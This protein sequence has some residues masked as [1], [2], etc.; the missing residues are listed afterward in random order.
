[1]DLG[2]TEMGLQT[3]Y[4]LFVKFQSHRIEQI[5][6][7]ESALQTPCF[8]FVTLR[9]HQSERIGPTEFAWPA[10]YVPIAEIG[11]TEFMRLVT[12]RLRYALTLALS[13]HRDD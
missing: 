8:L 9:F 5:G 13:S 12:P 2:L 4:F 1:M 10:L 3:P 6:P 11:P 7:T